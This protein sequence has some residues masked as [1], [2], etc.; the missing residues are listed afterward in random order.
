MILG[1]GSLRS[2]VYFHLCPA[3]SPENVAVYTRVPTNDRLQDRETGAF[4][5]TACSAGGN[6]EEGTCWRTGTA[7]GMG[8]AHREQENAHKIQASQEGIGHILYEGCL[9][10]CPK[11]Y[12]GTYVRDA[13]IF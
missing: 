11:N 1:N 4:D 13:M 5:E 12:D 6:C 7:E 8:S 2:R 3:K 10:L 9:R